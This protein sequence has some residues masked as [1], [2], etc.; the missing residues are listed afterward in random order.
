[1]KNRQIDKTKQVRI[2]ASLHRQLKILSAK[3][4][5]TIKQILEEIIQEVLGLFREYE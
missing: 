5:K 4:G 2:N 3:E 1:M